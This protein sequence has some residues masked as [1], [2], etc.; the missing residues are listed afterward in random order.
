VPSGEETAINGKWTKGP[1][2][3]LF[4]ILKEEF[5][6]MPFIAEDL[7]DIDEDVRS[8]MKQFDLPGM[9]V[10]L[11]A[12]GED[13]PHSSYAPHHHIHHCIVYTGTHD[14]NTVRGWFENEAQSEDKIRLSYYVNYPLN[15]H[16]VHTA[17]I[18][19]AMM[20]IANLVIFP[21][22]DILGLGQDSIMN[23]PSVAKG[24][25]TWRQKKELINEKVIAELQD[26]AT[27][28]DRK[29]GSL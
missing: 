13:L 19:L 21:M 3:A 5:P 1:A 14:N 22:Q 12:F 8:L 11:F 10:L 2:A 6:N 29:S 28:Y 9:K 23:K 18:R 24:N 27:I 15:K 7:G 25:W 20:S 16:N 26:M 4:K 17:M